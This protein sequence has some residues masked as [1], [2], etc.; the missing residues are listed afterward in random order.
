M[1]SQKITKDVQT[2]GENVYQYLRNSIIQLQIKPGQTIN[3]SELSTFLKVSR[4]PVRDALIQLA[5]D[6][7]VTTAPQKSTIV[8]KLDISHSK[9]ERFMRACVEERVLEEFLSCQQKTHIQQL[10]ENLAQ[11]RRMLETKEIR[12]FLRS[13][14][15]F[16]SIFF[17]ATSHPFSL[18][19][20]LNMSCHY[21]RIR[22]LSLSEI[23]VCEQS[24][25]QHL[26]ILQ[27][28]QEK[29]QADIRRIINLHIVEKQDEETRMRHRYPEL[30][31]ETAGDSLLS[32]KIWEEDFLTTI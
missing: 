31:T 25:R 21:Y 27:M 30:F 12:G 14:D 10:Q 3:I 18:E 2:A 4:S 29:K 32:H 22:L 15:D 16:H 28:V 20:I 23:N 11:Q 17:Q 7:L 24:Y 6:G 1:A 19:N 9:D 26:D 8:S 5:R 13:D